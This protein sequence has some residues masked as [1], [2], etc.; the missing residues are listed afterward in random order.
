M[1]ICYKGIIDKQ[2][3][4]YLHVLCLTGYVGY[5]QIFLDLNE[6]DD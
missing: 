4:I 6:R 5:D 1:H 2:G 3:A